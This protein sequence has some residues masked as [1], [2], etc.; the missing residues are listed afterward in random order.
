MFSTEHVS[1]L[2]GKL[3]SH[4]IPITYDFGELCF[5]VWLL[6][7]ICVVS[8]YAC[9]PNSPH[10]CTSRPHSGSIAVR[11]GVTC[12]DNM[13]AIITS[14]A[15]TAEAMRIL[16]IQ[17]NTPTDTPTSSPTATPTSSPTATSTSFSETT[18]RPRDSFGR[19]DK[20]AIGVAV[21]LGIFLLGAILFY[22]LRRRKRLQ[23]QPLDQEV[24]AAGGASDSDPALKAELQGSSGIAISG[25]TG[26]MF[27]K[28]ELDNTQ[29]GIATTISELA[30]D[31]P[32]DNIQ[33]LHG[34]SSTP[35]I[36]TNG[37][38]PVSEPQNLI[39]HDI[40]KECQQNPVQLSVDPNPGSAVAGL[41]DWS[42]FHTLGEP[43][44]SAR[45]SMT[46]VHK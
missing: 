25:S 37:T 1:Q 32:K 4:F 11:D 30:A 8:N 19:G 13:V 24:L 27:E 28:A 22:F 35:K 16:L 45:S 10:L 15:L 40:D 5:Q 23:V 6:T 42:N 3:F 17:S 7:R 26:A 34:N 36:I 38:I 20:I 21:P 41:W 29:R 33:E 18:S 39:S 12:P 46:G 9:D 44:E 2:V 31:L 43:N 14:T